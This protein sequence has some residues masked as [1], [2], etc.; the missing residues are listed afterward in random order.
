ML[1][2]CS[3]EHGM[4]NPWKSFVLK[5]TIISNK[6][7]VRCT[8]SNLCPCYGCAHAMQAPPLDILVNTYRACKCR[9][10]STCRLSSLP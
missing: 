10:Q 8:S 5:L 6:Q 9:R 2:R 4:L 3:L 7:S 1:I